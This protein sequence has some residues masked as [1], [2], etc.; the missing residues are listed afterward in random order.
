[1][2]TL[3]EHFN[4]NKSIKKFYTDEFFTPK[5]GILDLSGFSELEE[6]EIDGTELGSPLTKII[7]KGCA[8]L[9]ELHLW[10]NNLTD[11]DFLNDLPHPEK[12][13]EL[14]IPSNNFAK[15]DLRI[16]EKFINLKK[17]N[18][19][20]ISYHGREKDKYNRFE[21]SLKPLSKLNHL[22]HL[23][24]S[25]TDINSGLEYLPARMGHIGKL[26]DLFQFDSCGAISQE[27]EPFG[28]DIKKWQEA[29]PA[30]MVF[31]S[32]D[33][34]NQAEAEARELKIENERLKNQNKFL[35]EQLQQ[36]ELQAQII[37]IPKK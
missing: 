9:E 15:S 12:L 13:K 28:G 24:I 6:L 19:S 36:T 27:L 7:L 37:H 26:I 21:G 3:Q 30:K 1:M 35:L 22:T 25:R 5:G 2:T 29:H 16:F 8:N 34:K 20:N 23:N 10:Y 17:L 31:S 18:I 14:I 4:N 33:L 11:L 32:L